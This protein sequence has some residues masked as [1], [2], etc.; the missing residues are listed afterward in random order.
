[1]HFT[2]VSEEQVAKVIKTS[3]STTCK[4]DPF[5]SYLLKEHCD[6]LLPGMTKIINNSLTKGQFYDHWKRAIVSPLLKKAGL[7][8]LAQNYRPVSQLSFIS[9]TVEKCSISQLNNYLDVNGL[10]KDHQSAYKSKFSTETALCFLVNNLLW[11]MEDGR[12]SVLVSIDLT[13]AFDTVDH[14]VLVSVLRQNFG[15]DGKALDWTKSYLN[16]RSM[17]VQVGDTL[18]SARTFNFSVPQ[19]S[20]VGPI[21]F[22]LYSSTIT[23]C[24]DSSQELGGYADDHFIRDSFSPSVKNDEF[25]CVAR[26]EATLDRIKDWMNS[27]RLKMNPAKTEIVMFGTKQMMSKTKTRTIRVIE[28]EVDV[29]SHL[30]YLGVTLDSSLSLQIHIQSLCKNVAA[31]IR[32]LSQIRPFIDIDT[33]KLLA[34][35]L[36]LSQLD[37]ANSILCGLPC[38]SIKRLQRVQNWAA[39]VVLQRCKY[40][41]SKDA[42]KILH[43]L[44]IKDRIDY[45]ILTLVHKCIHK[46]APPYLCNLVK[47]KTF[48]RSTRLSKS[49]LTLVIPLAKKST[50][51]ARSFSIYGPNLWNKLPSGIQ[52]IDDF[53][54]FKRLLK[55][56]IF[57]LCFNN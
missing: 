56:H 37:Y 21:L 36:I 33:A 40:D 35:S 24:I 7:D 27:N 18:S 32:R 57:K 50:L 22:N 3:K 54:A 26:M 17:Q 13:A 41:S 45:K 14:G 48:T 16:N 31:S 53:N 20:C 34:C 11:A 25:Q 2:P 29:N 38:S 43:W 30:K 49:S 23:D 46:A 4:S 28:Q 39:K 19:G 5:P 10:H 55:T 9:K 44:P 52:Q 47:I 51:A 8:L 15:V 42:L 1:M 6:I 12:I